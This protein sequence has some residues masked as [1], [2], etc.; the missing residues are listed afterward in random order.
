[1]K[2]GSADTRRQRRQ[3]SGK[4]KGAEPLNPRA[5]RIVR[6]SRVLRGRFGGSR[7]CRNCRDF[8]NW[9][10]LPQSMP[11]PAKIPITELEHQQTCHP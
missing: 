6:K 4:L 8:R 7:W 9:R 5:L 11:L 2:P 3:G 10:P 1:V